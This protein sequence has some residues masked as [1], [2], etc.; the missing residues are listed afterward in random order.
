MDPEGG[1]VR[2]LPYTE[3]V[4]EYLDASDVLVSKPGGLSS[5]EAAVKEIPLVHM[6][7]L[8]GWEEDN[9][10]FFTARGMSLTGEGSG[11]MAAAAAR[12]LSDPAAAERMCAC[13]RREINKHAASDILDALEELSAS[14]GVRRSTE[15]GESAET[16]KSTGDGGSAVTGTAP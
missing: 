4:G 12:L 13:Q 1:Q 6:A 3:R 11:E 16:G 2:A 14:G 9:V 7:P 15:A 8:P 5:T 10:R